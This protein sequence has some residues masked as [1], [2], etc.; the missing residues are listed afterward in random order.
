MIRSASLQGFVA[1]LGVLVSLCGNAVDAELE[2]EPTVGHGWLIIPEEEWMAVAVVPTGY[3]RRAY[4]CSASGR[5]TD[6]AREIRAKATLVKLESRRAADQVRQN[7]I[8]CVDDLRRLATEV[9]NG[10]TETPAALAAVFAETEFR[11]AEH[12]FRKAQAYETSGDTAKL[13]HDISACATHLFNASTWSDANLHRLDVQAVRE[14][15]TLGQRLT[16]GSVSSVQQSRIRGGLR[17][18]GK[19]IWRFAGRAKL[20]PLPAMDSSAE[21]GRM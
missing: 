13:G 7:L 9:Q 10:K 11:L 3:F 5:R 14:A 8:D 17:D 16:Q 2:K 18:I 1:S 15:R 20:G 21:D 12:H 19:A 4:D 6:A